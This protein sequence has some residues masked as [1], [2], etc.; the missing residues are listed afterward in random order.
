MTAL[1]TARPLP[2]KSTVPAPSA[3]PF[4]GLFPD[5]R[6]QRP[7]AWFFA[8]EWLEARAASD[9][10]TNSRGPDEDVNV[11]IIDLLCRWAVSD[12]HPGALPG[13]DPLL[14]PPDT[15]DR[16]AAAV[17]YRRQA[18]HRLLALGLCDRGDLA[19]RRRVGWRMTAEETH[20]RDLAVA[21]RCYAL[22]AN[23]TPPD[24]RDRQALAGVWSRL[25]DHTG[26]YVQAMQIMARRR[27]GLGARLDDTALSWLMT[28]DPDAL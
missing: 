21:S 13:R 19:R 2:S 26:D 10:P 22:A 23:L 1:A 8:E 6:G 18:D 7:V 24:R 27:L 25:A 5:W 3:T 15:A 4:R 20:R 11:Y 28:G 14:L 17:H 9:F 16:G 12:P